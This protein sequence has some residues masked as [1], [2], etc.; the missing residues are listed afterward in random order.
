VALCARLADVGIWQTADV[1][2]SLSDVAAA[3]SGRLLFNNVDID[4]ISIDSRTIEPG[5]LF[6]PIVAER[7]GHAFLSGAAERGA[8]AHLTTGLTTGIPAVEVRDTAAALS[9][10][11]SA[12][13]QRLTGEVIAITGSVGKTT[14]KDLLSSVLSRV[15]TTHASYRSFNNELG[16]PL[17]LANAPDDAAFVVL[18]MGAR[19]TGHIADLCAVAAPTIGIVLAVGA[20]HTEMFGDLDG[21]AQAKGE[22]VEALGESATAV[23]NAGDERVLA[24]AARTRARV[25]TFGAH[26][27][28]R[29]DGVTVDERL[30]PR[31]TIESAW[32]SV[33]VELASS[34]MHT[35]TNALAAAAAALAVG[36]DLTAIAE[37]LSAVTVSPW[38]MEISHTPAGALVINDSYNANPMSMHAAIDSL[39]QVRAKRRIA[40]LG[41]MAEL[42]AEQ[43]SL[44][45]AV[46]DRLAAAGVEVVA[47]GAPDYGAPGVDAVEEVPPVL[48]ELDADTA[49]LIKG[50]RVA[51]LE[52]LVAMLG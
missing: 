39:L 12:A 35:V 43:A 36:G 26:G 46:G 22:M 37:G 28:V 29:A 34:G 4:G 10:L 17:T 30:R 6:V 31:F 49:V 25:L 47:V 11:G 7:D 41:V 24:M 2:F 52:R 33:A 32:G 20:A 5:Q 14:T 1:Q 51:G 48:G 42:G 16:V 23:L 3:T 13:R 40:V 9:A 19:G 44:H 21:V 50:S 18:E 45:R 27:E 15:G 8:A 38:R